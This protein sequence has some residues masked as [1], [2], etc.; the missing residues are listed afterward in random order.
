[1]QIEKHCQCREEVHRGR[2]THTEL[3]RLQ[4]AD[5]V[6][7]QHPSPQSFSLAAK[8]IVFS[9]RERQMRVQILVRSPSESQLF[10]LWLVNLWKSWAIQLEITSGPR[11]GAPSHVWVSM[12]YHE[13]GGVSVATCMCWL[14]N[15]RFQPV[16]LHRCVCF[17]TWAGDQVNSC[18]NLWSSHVRFPL[19][20]F[21]LTSQ[22]SDGLLQRYIQKMSF[23]QDCS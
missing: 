20:M 15:Q 4:I 22:S 17:S 10:P 5:C 1:M 18:V 7:T 11:C 8:Y 13:A 23:C 21:T 3:T 12:C 2:Y 9:N 14:N 16:F 6:L 19:V